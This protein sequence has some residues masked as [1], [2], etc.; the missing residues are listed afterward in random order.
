[1]PRT[2]SKRV[3]RR[4]NYRKARRLL[5]IEMGG[6]CHYCPRVRRLEFHHKARRLWRAEKT[7]RWVRLARYRR[8]WL[9]GAVVLACPKC[10]KRLGQ[11]PPGDEDRTAWAEFMGDGTEA[12]F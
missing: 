11:P 4:R 8:E 3:R 6:R 12:P 1:M 9:A 2:T 5:I 7:S 10:N